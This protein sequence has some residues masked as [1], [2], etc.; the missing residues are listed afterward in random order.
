MGASLLAIAV[1]QS[2]SMATDT[3]SSRASS[4]PQGITFQ[5]GVDCSNATPA[6]IS[7]EYGAVTSQTGM[8]LK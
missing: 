1:Y 2:T 3:P 6:P 8:P 4:L 5:T 7:P